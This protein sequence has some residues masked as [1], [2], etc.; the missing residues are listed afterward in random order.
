[1]STSRR[2]FLIGVAASATVAAPA[3]AQGRV[4]WRMVTA[5]PRD[6]PG[7]GVSARRISERV[8][9][10]TAGR[11]EISVFAA[12]EIV[13]ALG[14]FDAVASGVAQAGHG[15]SFFQASKAPVAQLFTTLPFGLSPVEH[16]S[17]LHF[18]GGQ[19]LWDEAY[20]PFGVMAMEGGNTGPSMA[21]WFSRPIAA[22]EDLRGLRIRVAGL[23]AEM[24][25]RLGAV[26]VLVAPGE[27]FP[28]L[29]SGVIDAVEFLGPWSDLAQ[30]FHQAA[31][32]YYA[33]GVTKP[34]GSSELVVSAAAFAGL[35]PDL[36]AALRQAAL[37]ETYAGLA[38]AERAN[39]LALGLLQTQHG[40]LSEL[41]P[42]P[43]LAAMRQAAAGLLDDLAQRD[44]ASR[45]IVESYGA[46]LQQAQ[47]WS[48]VGLGGFL[49]ART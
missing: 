29:R 43:V 6:L 28:A 5:W 47:R 22:P 3:I 20:A 41:M 34:N 26:P 39:A 23:G 25:R 18:G 27:I 33:P 1:M 8:R 31:K 17:W 37:A 10:L 38:E 4:Q 48:R 19:A 44:G 12:G 15:A 45:R 16:H 24:Y 14:V 11:F 36:Q 2:T 40:V 9:A 49:A 13:P 32:H 7:P 30:G 21:G 46:H 35:A 42:Q